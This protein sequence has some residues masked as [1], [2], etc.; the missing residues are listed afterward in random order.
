MMARAKRA[1]FANGEPVTMR[2]ALSRDTETG[3]VTS[4]LAIPTR[5]PGGSETT[6]YVY[7][8]R[9]D[10]AAGAFGASVRMTYEHLLTADPVA[11]GKAA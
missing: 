3:T 5:L 4:V 6:F 11:V 9:M 8:V 7:R 10:N 1:K 2:K